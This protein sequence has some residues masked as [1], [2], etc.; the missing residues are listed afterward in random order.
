M[1]RYVLL[2][3]FVVL[4]QSLMAEKAYAGSPF[5]LNGP[6]MQPQCSYYSANS[7]REAA[8]KITRGF[9]NV[10]AN[11][12]QLPN[13]PGAWCLVTSTRQIQCYYD[14]FRSC[15]TQTR[16]K[17]AI[18]ARSFKRPPPSKEFESDVENLF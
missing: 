8:N 17:N 15:Q 9:C 16:S 11:E 12:I 14:N 6:G 13:G 4:S 2:L 1:Q 3:I 18:C 7:C 5:C 10:N